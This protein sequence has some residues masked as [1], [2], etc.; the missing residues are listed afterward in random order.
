MKT[1]EQT[2]G[3]SVLKHGEMVMDRYH[4]LHGWLCNGAQLTM[5][6][7]LPSWLMNSSLHEWLV[8][9]LPS[10]EVSDMYQL[11][12]DCGK[13]YC[14]TIDAE[15]HRH[16]TE[17]ALVSKNKWLSISGDADVAELIG[18]DMDIHMLRPESVSEFA[19]R[20]FAVLLLLTGLCEIHANAEM[21]GGFESDSFKIKWKK[22]EQRGK[23]IIK[24]VK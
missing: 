22:I 23:A 24:C 3:V 17:H 11:Y 7:R 18:M 21:F 20:R 16:F 2:T 9:Q 14:L 13:P 5:R 1:T 15:G 6:W 4:D 19:S 12:H 10:L 8:A